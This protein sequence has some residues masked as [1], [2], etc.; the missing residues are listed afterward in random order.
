MRPIRL[1]YS[2]I[3]VRLNTL[4]K[5]SVN[6]PAVLFYDHQS[7]IS[8][9]EVILLT[10]LQSLLL[11]ASDNYRLVL[12][13]PSGLLSTRASQLAG[14]EIHSIRALEVG[15]TLSPWRLLGYVLRVLMV[16]LSLAFLIRKY[17]ARVIHANSIR[18]GVVACLAAPFVRVKV[19]IHLHDV[20]RLSLI[21]RFIGWLFTKLAWKLV[22]I[23]DYVQKSA[24]LAGTEL[25][26]KCVTI[27][28]GI[29]TTLFDPQRYQQGEERTR[30]LTE[31]AI[32]SGS[33]KECWPLMA[34]GGQIT[35]WKGQREALEALV[36]LR[37]KFPRAGLIIAGAT[38]FQQKSARYN[39]TQFKKELEDFIREK[40]LEEAVWFC[41]ERTD[42]SRL[43]VGTDLLILP[44]WAEPFG[45]ILVE[46]MALELPVVASAIG[47]PLEIICPG[48]NGLLFPS[49]DSVALAD[50]VEQLF[51][52]PD[53]IGNMGKAARKTVEAR[54]S[55]ELMVMQFLDLYQKAITT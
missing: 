10:L 26:R 37:E 52:N 30:H 2:K 42:I 1:V 17:Q 15:Y 32:I 35:P 55:K 46:A 5:P 13:C 49:K 50:A 8:G 41:G 21:D 4:K 20:L 47:G 22:A 11:E 29:D 33:R 51:S 44:S 43:L 23:S 18:S 40:K 36:I 54:F 48:E 14:L 31:W 6:L 24:G 12:V 38:K 45:L 16:S 27:Y 3:K 39:N 28:N 9:G 25:G 19:I 7:E 53:Y 34:L